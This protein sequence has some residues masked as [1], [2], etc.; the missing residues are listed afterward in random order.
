MAG[1]A[2]EPSLLRLPRYYH[3]LKQLFDEGQA[4][5]TSS[6]IAQELGIDETLV[7]KDLAITG[8]AGKPRVGFDVESLL[9][10]LEEHIGL[11]ESKEA[12]LIGA[13][14][15]GQA[16]ACYPGFERYGLKILAIFDN[17]DTK[18][19]M[20]VNDI[21][22]LPSWKAPDLVRRTGVKIVI[23]AIPAEAAQAMA[24]SLV[25]AGAE[26]IWNFTGERL[27]VPSDIVVLNQDLAE[28]LLLLS[29]RLSQMRLQQLREIEVTPV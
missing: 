21:E 28:S 10:L 18:I 15:L 22:V 17:D 19:G 16:L 29:Q 2:S 11:K 26:A 7:R 4:C 8:A 13:G 24:N 27:R 25:E 5:V 3:L 14:R 6:G 23:L 9:R 12:F 1:R 20:Q